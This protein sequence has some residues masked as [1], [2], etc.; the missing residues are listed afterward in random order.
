[1]RIPIGINEAELAPVYID[2]AESPHFLIIGDSES[3]KTTLL[4]SIIDGIAASNSPNEARFILGDYRRSMLGLIPEGYQAGYGSTAPQF[5]KNMN[6]LAA[7]VSKR[8]PGPD[9]TPQ[10]LRERSWWN[11][12]ELYVIVDDY[13]LVATSQGNPVSAL[14][15]HLPHARDLGFHL[16]IARRSG[17]AS[18]AMYEATLARMKDLGSAALVMSCSRDEGVMVGTTR[19]GPKPPGRGTFVTRNSEG[20]IQ[21]AWMPQPE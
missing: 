1:M 2:F 18:R 16:I 7:Y 12:P 15:E 21:T 11:G 17:G 8:T 9:V 6:D 3:G 19:P 4:R 14:V 5:T 10:Q 13:D 20:L